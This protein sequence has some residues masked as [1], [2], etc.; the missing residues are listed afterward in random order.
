MIKFDG[1]AVIINRCLVLLLCVVSLCSLVIGHTEGF[2]V[3]L[4][5]LSVVSNRLLVLLLCVVSLCSL[6]VG[7][8]EGLMIKLEGAGSLFNLNCRPR[9]G[10]AKAYTTN[11]SAPK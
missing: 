3:E 9:F 10:H 8:T 7:G 1:L 11:L 4:D 2:V 6:V 5:D